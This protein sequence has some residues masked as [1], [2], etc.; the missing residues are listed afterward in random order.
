[1]HNEKEERVVYPLTDQ[2]LTHGQREDL[3]RTMQSI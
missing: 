3:V 2:T 1:M